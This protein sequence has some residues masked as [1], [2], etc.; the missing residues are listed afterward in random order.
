MLRWFGVMFN[1]VFD[2][3]LEFINFEISI[4]TEVENLL[5]KSYILSVEYGH[6]GLILHHSL[7]QLFL[8]FGELIELLL[9]IH[10]LFFKV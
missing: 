10:I 8:A 6:D 2:C 9:K 7:R 3:R 1:V 4:I 5:M